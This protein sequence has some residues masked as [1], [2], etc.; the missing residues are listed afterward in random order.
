[1]INREAN[2]NGGNTS[3]SVVAFNQV[4]NGGRGNGRVVNREV[5]VNGGNMNA[6]GGNSNVGSAYDRSERRQEERRDGN[7]VNNKPRLSPGQEELIKE[8][9]QC[10]YCSSSNGDRISLEVAL[11]ER[12][13]L[14]SIG[15][16]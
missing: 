8:F 7:M 14:K 10:G 6:N 3:G 2:V 5:N 12:K 16:L 15:Q 13:A 1:V 9:R 4:G 11:Q